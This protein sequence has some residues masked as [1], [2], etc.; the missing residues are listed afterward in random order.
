MIA[1]S[2]IAVQRFGVNIA[3]IYELKRVKGSKTVAIGGRV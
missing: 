1:A 3:I 2:V